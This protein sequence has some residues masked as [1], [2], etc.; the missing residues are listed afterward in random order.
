MRELA[1]EL[2]I[3][4]AAKPDSQEICFV[5]NGDYAAFIDA[6]FR[7][8]GI[9]PQEVGRRAGD[10]RRQGGR[11]ACRRA[12]F[13]RRASGAACGSPRASRLY[14]IS[15]EPASRRVIDR[16]RSGTAARSSARERGEL[17]LDR[18]SGGAGARGSEDPQQARGGGCDARPPSIGTRAS[19]IRFDEPQRAR[20][21]RPGRGVLFGRSGAGRRLD[22]VDR[23][24]EP[25]GALSASRQ[26][27][28]LGRAAAAAHRDPQS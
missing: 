1:R 3:P 14:V 26:G 4:T 12:P 6:Y 24:C 2:G 15:T 28:R 23:T 27:A 7:E 11:R 18:G 17:D 25:Q 8:Q 10:R 5:P 20:H 9:A 13:H 19:K 21:S 22:R 16:T